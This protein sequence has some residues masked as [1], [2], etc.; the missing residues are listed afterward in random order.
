MADL[1]GIH[2]PLKVHGD[3][4]Q[5]AFAEAHIVPAHKFDVKGWVDTDKGPATKF[6]CEIGQLGAGTAYYQMTPQEHYEAAK[7]THAMVA[8]NPD[9][10][11][12]LKVTFEMNDG[13]K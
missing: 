5:Q 3:L 11:V 13:S 7:T 4:D 6:E 1:P 2:N 12:T 10:T 8:A 9:G